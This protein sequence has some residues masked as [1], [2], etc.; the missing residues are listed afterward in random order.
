MIIS[1]N[2]VTHNYTIPKLFTLGQVDSNLNVVERVTVYVN[3][4]TTFDHTYD[5]V[6]NDG[7]GS[8]G[9]TTSVTQS[10]TVTE[11]THYDVSLDTS[12]ISTFVAYDDLEED[13]VL[14]WAFD[15]DSTTKASV[16]S[17]H[18]TSVL[19]QK[20]RVLNPLKYY[21]NSTSPTPWQVRE[22]QELS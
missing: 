22:E 10:K 1:S 8:T 20:D 6:I 3:S 9:I 16:Q 7:P 14:G 19:E 11:F 13:T 4:S 17:A 12:G 2:S 18:E 21:R 15:K 5:T